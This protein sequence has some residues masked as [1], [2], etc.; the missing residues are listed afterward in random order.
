[1][2]SASGSVKLGTHY[3]RSRA[4]SFD[5]LFCFSIDYLVLALFASAM[6]AL[7]ASAPMDCLAGT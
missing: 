1:M 3:L 6:L 2:L 7:V 4:L 5:H